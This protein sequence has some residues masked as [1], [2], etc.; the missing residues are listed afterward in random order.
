M[1]YGTEGILEEYEIGAT[2]F[3]A[4]IAT[5]VLTLEDIVLTV[6][7]T[8]RGAPEIGVGNVIGSVVFGVTAKLGIILLVGGS[9]VVDDDVLSWHLPVLVVMTALAAYFIHTGR[10]RRWHGFV[11]LALYVAYWIVS[12]TL[13]GRSPDR[14]GLTG[15]PITPWSWPGAPGRAVARSTDG[16]RARL[17]GGPAGE[18]CGPRT[19]AAARPR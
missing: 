2:L 17:R 13:L 14:S 3:G 18:R 4:T 7:P 1:S 12:F 9:I 15:S 11:L 5:L 19:A 6:E 10:L 16:R 8:R